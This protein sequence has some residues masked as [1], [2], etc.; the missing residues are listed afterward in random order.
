MKILCVEDGSVN[1]DALE[2][3]GLRDGK[4]L[5]YRQGA[6]MPFVLQL[7][8]VKDV[9]KEKWDKLRAY[10]EESFKE[11][12]KRFREYNDMFYSG[13]SVTDED[14]LSKMQEL[15]GSENGTRNNRQSEMVICL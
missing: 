6:N 3:D 1:L 14:I 4:I 11:D 10:I 9:W 12:E 5:V 2:T 7:P 13:C 8:D 15:E